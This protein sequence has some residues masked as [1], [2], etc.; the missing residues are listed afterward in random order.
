[1]A[2]TLAL[3]LLV[4]GCVLFAAGRTGV[5]Q[6]PEPIRVVLW[7]EG[8]DKYQPLEVVVAHQGSCQPGCLEERLLVVPPG[9]P[10]RVR[11]EALQVD[12]MSHSELAEVRLGEATTVRCNGEPSSDF[13]CALRS[14]GGDGDGSAS[15]FGSAR[16]EPVV[17]GPELRVSVRGV[18]TRDTCKCATAGNGSTAC[19]S[20][21]QS[22]AHPT[23]GL[24][25]RLT[26]VPDVSF[27]WVTG[28]WGPCDPSLC[29]VPGSRSRRPV[30]CA[31]R[32]SGGGAGGLSSGGGVSTSASAPAAR[33]RCEGAAPASG[34]P[35]AATPECATPPACGRCF[36]LGLAPP[37][38]AGA[39]GTGLLGLD[40]EGSSRVVV[41][42]KVPL[43]VRLVPGFANA[44]AAAFASCGPGSRPGSSA[45]TAAGMPTEERYLAAVASGSGRLELVPGDSGA[46]FGARATFVLQQ[47]SPSSFLLR[48]VAPREGPAL[49]GAGAATAGA[50]G[51]ASESGMGAGASLSSPPGGGDAASPSGAAGSGAGASGSG[52]SSSDPTSSATGASSGGSTSAG[53]GG[54]GDAAVSGGDDGWVPL[55][56]PAS[57]EGA[58]AA[59][60]AG[61]A[62]EALPDASSDFSG[63]T[64]S[65]SAAAPAA[66]TAGG[67]AGASAGSGGGGGTAAAAGIDGKGEACLVLPPWEL[68]SACRFASGWCCPKQL[69]APGLRHQRC[70]I[71]E[72]LGLSGVARACE[73]SACTKSSVGLVLLHAGTCE[74]RGCARIS[75]FSECEEAARAMGLLP[76][77]GARRVVTTLQQPRSCAWEPG[78]PELGL[79][80]ALWLNVQ[81]GDASSS[82]P[83]PAGASEESRQLCR[84]GGPEPTRYTWKVGAWGA[85]GLECG[86]QR[87]QRAVS[88]QQLPEGRDVAEDLCRE[89]AAAGE[90]PPESEP[91][92][93]ERCYTVATHT[94]CRGQPRT[95]AVDG[96]AA[97]EGGLAQELSPSGHCVELQA[98]ETAA[99]E[100]CRA[101]CSRMGRCV[102]FSL[103][104][105]DLLGLSKAAQTESPQSS[106]DLSGR[107]LP[108]CCFLSLAESWDGGF[109]EASCHL[110]RGV[111]THSGCTC[112]VGWVFTSLAGRAS[113]PC[114]ADQ[115]G[116][117]TTQD[118]GAEAVC[119]TAFSE[120]CGATR[121]QQRRW[122][123]CDPPSVAIAA[124]STC[125]THL[126]LTRY[127]CAS[128]HSDSRCS[129]V[130]SSLGLPHAG[131][132]LTLSMHKPSGCVWERATSKLWLNQLVVA[133]NATD[134]S[135]KVAMHASPEFPELCS[136]QA[137]SY[138]WEAGAWSP[139]FADA[140]V[141]CRE[142]RQRQVLC[143]RGSLRGGRVAG[144]EVAEEARCEPAP[145]P[146]GVEECLP[147]SWE[148]IGALAELHPRSSAESPNASLVAEAAT[149]EVTRES[150]QAACEE[151]FVPL[152]GIQASRVR[153]RVGECCDG[154][155]LTVEL[156]IAGPPPG[157]ASATAASAASGAASPSD[158]DGNADGGAV[159]GRS[160][161]SSGEAHAP[162]SAGDALRRL[163]RAVRLARTKAPG[164]PHFSAAMARLAGKGLTVRVHGTYTWDSRGEWSSCSARCGGGT[165]SRE[166]AC[167]FHGYEDGED[168]TPLV[169]DEE[170][171][172]RCDASTKPASERSCHDRLCRQCPGFVLGP[173]YAVSGGST[174][175]R[176]GDTVFVTCSDGHGTADDQR[177]VPR[178]CEDGEWTPL[179]VSCGRSCDAPR[180]PAWKYVVTGEGQEHGAMRQVAC[181]YRRGLR[182]LDEVE[183]PSSVTVV[184][185]DGSWTQPELLSC[186]GDC[187]AVELSAAHEIQGEGVGGIFAP[188]DAVW[189]VAC[190]P[191]FGDPR[192]PETQDLRCLR[193]NWVGLVEI[194]KCRPSCAAYDFPEG[195]EAAGFANASDADA[196]GQNASADASSHSFGAGG[197]ANAS[198]V[199]GGMAHGETLTLRCRRGFGWSPAVVETTRC[200]NGRWSRVALECRRDCRAFNESSSGVD[201]GRYCV[202]ADAG[203]DDEA[204]DAS[205]GSGDAESLE[206]G[207]NGVR[208]GSLVRVGCLLG[209]ADGICR[210]KQAGQEDV[211][212]CEN[213]Q[214]L[215]PQKLSCFHECAPFVPGPRLSVVVSAAGSHGGAARSE[216]AA[217]TPIVVD[218]GKE[219]SSAGG[220]GAKRGGVLHGTRLV[221]TCAEGFSAAPSADDS[222]DERAREEAM[223]G[224]P[225]GQLLAPIDGVECAD[226]SWSALRLRCLPDCPHLSSGHGLIVSPGGSRAGTQRGVRCAPNGLTGSSVRA[227]SVAAVARC[228]EQG[229]WE[230]VRPGEEMSLSNLSTCSWMT[231]TAEDDVLEC[232]DGSRCHGWHCCSLPGRGGRARCPRNLPRMCNSRACGGGDHC[233]SVRCL[234]TGVRPCASRPLQL[235][236]VSRGC[237]VAMPGMWS[238]LTQGESAFVGLF[239]VAFCLTLVLFVVTSLV[240]RALQ[241]SLPAGAGA[242][243]LRAANDDA[244]ASGSSR[245]AQV[246]AMPAAV[247][248]DLDDVGP[249]L[250]GVTRTCSQRRLIAGSERHEVEE[251]DDRRDAAMSLQRMARE[252]LRSLPGLGGSGGGERGQRSQDPRR[253]LA[254]G[255]VGEPSSVATH[256]CFP[257]GH[258]CLCTSCASRAATAAT[259]A[260]GGGALP[261]GCPLCGSS[262]DFTIDAQ[263]SRAFA[264]GGARRQL[265]RLLEYFGGATTSSS[266]PFGDLGAAAAPPGYGLQ[267]P[268]SAD[269]LGRR[270]DLR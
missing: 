84:C 34:R 266:S 48:A 114:E 171:Q 238:K 193:G 217:E 182:D 129:Q 235:D 82:S 60:D 104:R 269:V 25:V 102:G 143:V 190:A 145:K 88:C 198:V 123:R 128:V 221:V 230:E 32:V 109:H 43:R 118:R 45:V 132:E 26:L 232:M 205:S 2:T 96:F 219:F 253:C 89:D 19:Y 251:D 130:A 98:P 211:I 51:G 18:Q 53:S 262:V 163:L 78:S 68:Q 149:A 268:R 61:L 181:R 93:V 153:V 70:V 151:N 62:L 220:S 166:L 231:S 94:R 36:R 134:P 160:A 208:H 120:A 144:S 126:R 133:V 58:T 122:D 21:L 252:T 178:R 199:R 214:W 50:G 99:P 56:A 175:S 265:T 75:S 222:A 5:D 64:A 137:E 77:G 165:Q 72:M 157:Y 263:P 186:A 224:A 39:S 187:Q 103:Y 256:L 24:L 85:C 179:E 250:L 42:G 229:T 204:S 117:C 20:A 150:L 4:F 172:S 243:V 259:A 66:P 69:D 158:A 67:G 162:S 174:R 108:R 90:R 141:P 189:R 52:A 1:M 73:A 30:H 40:S 71:N 31:A 54:L 227:T 138:R 16:Q 226:G 140:E 173:Q 240:L 74:D 215:A 207:G 194:P 23:Y 228:S 261:L 46:A 27:E 44:T 76:P 101:A 233:C 7:N 136:C 59:A 124:E 236:R 270:A 9:V 192:L 121:A 200:E 92:T 176:H 225:L 170:D 115:G 49:S 180:F 154:P 35:C 6:S 15:G 258:L 168:S 185:E 156:L 79:D 161:E 119:P 247:A 201:W 195:F 197:A 155:R 212:R 116:C 223:G 241:S 107:S 264:P 147:C 210:G 148:V 111:Q 267:A 80:P 184:C 239:I 242:Q 112:Q 87:R 183:A 97:E 100:L 216:S 167:V 131:P 125:L 164:H 3:L 83:T 152:L 33:W 38:L 169:R 29:V 191:G 177:L 110:A 248:E 10:Y 11:V 206:S 246:A 8:S 159:G 17:M 65:A 146:L 55:V 47:A 95:G 57:E 255:C 203:S 218:D 135:R 139:C 28:K 127:G 213:G 237:E 257:C 188:H 245:S 113:V 249:G 22:G 244:R 209:G 91:C 12:M 196:G 254:P 234:D 63:G 41:G 13:S 105:T 106:S 202:I 142:I 86:S 81:D 14:C 37:G 260:A